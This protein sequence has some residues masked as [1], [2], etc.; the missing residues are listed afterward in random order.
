MSSPSRLASNHYPVALLLSTAAHNAVTAHTEHW[1]MVKGIV[2][3][4]SPL[5]TSSLTLVYVLLN[6]QPSTLGT[7]PLERFLTGTQF[8]AEFQPVTIA[9]SAY[10]GR[11]VAVIEPPTTSGTATAKDRIL[12]GKVIPID[13]A[14]KAAL[15]AL[16]STL[17][18]IDLF[19]ELRTLRPQLPMLVNPQHGGYYLVP[20]GK[21]PKGP[22]T[23]AILIN[24]YTGELLE[25]ARI[26][27]R[28]I[29]TQPQAIERAGT[30]LPHLRQLSAAAP[31]ATLVRD[32]D[33][34][35][36]PS[37]HIVTDGQEVTVDLD[38]NVRVTP[39][40]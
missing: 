16:A 29:L 32:T 38:G 36:S 40:P 22:A 10:S 34:P 11:Y 23:L 8:Y 17:K 21:E 1:V 20:F 26:P 12:T 14:A 25:A 24:A 19:K 9:G 33:S 13:V 7:V 27:P 4:V 3:N 30:V 28:R 39:K 15:I 2:T 5:S 6:D 31:Y 35:Y 18:N 37:W